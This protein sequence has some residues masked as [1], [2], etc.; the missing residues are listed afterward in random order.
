MRNNAQTTLR[1]AFVVTFLKRHVEA[2]TRNNSGCTVM[3]IKQWFCFVTMPLF[4]S[5][6]L[7]QQ[8]LKEVEERKKTNPTTSPPA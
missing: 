2:G 8:H 4:L 6:S 1:D 5:R 7:C 3:D